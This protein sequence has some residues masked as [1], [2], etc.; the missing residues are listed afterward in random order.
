[1]TKRYVVFGL[2]VLVAIFGA[3]GVSSRIL[4]AAP[5]DLLPRTLAEARDLRPSAP[6]AAD[7]PVVALVLGGGGGLRGFAHLGVLRVLDEAGIEPDIVVGTSAGAVVGAAYASGMSVR[8]IEA[9][10]HRIELSSLVDWTL[11]PGGIVR[12]DK[13]S[14]HHSA[15][16]LRER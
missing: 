4:A 6:G 5:L 16:G 12:G 3:S 10:D 15:C 1:M 7:R 14:W 2:A 13:C 11:A 9:A 8:E